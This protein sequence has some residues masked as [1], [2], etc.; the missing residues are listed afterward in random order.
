MAQYCTADFPDALGTRLNEFILDQVDERLGAG[1]G[2]GVRLSLCD[3]DIEADTW[4][5]SAP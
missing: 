3:F 4:A 1:V 5:L 2:L